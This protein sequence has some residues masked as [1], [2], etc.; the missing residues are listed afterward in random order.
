M[1]IFDFRQAF[2]IFVGIVI[3]AVAAIAGAASSPI[4]WVIAFVL[5]LA[6]AFRARN[7][8]RR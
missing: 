3:G 4:F 1:V 2:D 7:V 6:T 8:R 5:C